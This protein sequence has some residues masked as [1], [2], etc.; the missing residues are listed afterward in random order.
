MGKKIK[1]HGKYPEKSIL[2]KNEYSKLA[3]GILHHNA[4]NH[5]KSLLNAK[6]NDCSEKTGANDKATNLTT[7]K[8]ELGLTG[9]SE[10]C[11]NMLQ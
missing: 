10:K 8:Y 11:K 9:L 2:S 7:T 5:D 3:N 4:K 1:S 6:L